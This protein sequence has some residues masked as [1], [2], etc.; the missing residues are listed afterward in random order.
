MWINWKRF[1]SG[2]FLLASLS[3]LLFGCSDL[4]S[5]QTAQNGATKSISGVVSDPDTGLPL[6]NAKVTAYAIDASGAE[7]TTALSV[8]PASVTSNQKGA[9]LLHIPADYS[10][11]LMIEAEVPPTELVGKLS[12]LVFSTAG[13]KIRSAVPKNVISKTTI[14]PVMV[15]FATDAVYVFVQQNSATGGF[16]SDNI[17]KATIILETFFGPNFT[18][19]PPPKSATDSNTSK[20]QQDLIVSIIALNSV[21]GNSNNG[22]NMATIVTA[23]VSDTGLGSII[24]DSIKSGVTAAATT[25]AAAGTLPPEYL[26]SVAINT[27][28]SNAQSAPV[29]TPVLTDTT[30]PSAPANLVATPVSAKNVNLTWDAATDSGANPT[31][32]AGYSICR[33][34]SSNVY[35]TIDTVGPS[36]TSYSDFFAAAQTGYSYKVI[37]FDGARNLSE[38]SNVSS[39]TT[40]QAT[41]SIPPSKPAGLVCKGLIDAQNGLPA[42]IKTQWLQSTKTN[43]DGT[44]IPAA[45]YNVYR[46]SQLIATVAETSYSDKTVLAGTDYTYYVKASDA[47][48]DLSLASQTLTIRIPAAADAT[49]PVTTDLALQSPVLYNKVPLA[50]TASTRGGVTCNVYRDAVLI[51]TGIKGGT[52]SDASVSPRSKYVYTVTASSGSGESS[53]GNQLA[54]TTPANPN[55]TDTAPPT[56]P[57]NLV[58]VSVT[59]RS[60]PLT[61]T[62]STK[63]DGDKI[64]AGYDVLRGDGTGKGF[65]KIATVGQPGYTDTTVVPSTAYSYQ[66]MSFGSAG[67]RSDASAA[68]VVTT[69]TAVNLADTTAPTSPALALDSPATSGAVPLAWTASTKS[70]GDQVV[71]GYLVYRD[72]AQIADVKSGLSFTDTTMVAGTA[73]AY[74]VKA[75]DNAGNLSAASNELHVATPAAAPNTYTIYGK[76][77]LNGAG[78]AGVILSN[79]TIS[80]VS[81]AN[82]NYSFT[83]VANGSYSL[84]PSSTGY[85]RFT[86]TSR[87]VFISNANVP[88]QDFA[89]M[90]SGT[91]TGG[92]TY[93]DGTIIGGITYP[94]GTVIGGVLYPSATVIGGVTYPTGTVIGGVLY[95]NGVIVGGV[96]YPSGTV[97]G[98]TAFPVG[99]LTAG[100]IYPTGTLIGGVIYPTG[101]VVGGVIYPTGAVTGGVGFPAGSVVG[102]LGWLP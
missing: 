53:P 54:V 57:A 23:L 95:P 68:W 32:V 75:Y 37:A 14:P 90:L 70:N 17:Q 56:V 5:S 60:V 97:V 49:L 41:D 7:S 92:V 82:G 64:V 89:A 15:S 65:V 28:I 88:G 51:A 47:N 43:G 4:G 76:V 16:S 100:L 22:T 81:D 93:P 48:S 67:L 74:T 83:G 87:T 77:T 33:A 40:L 71:A 18:Q 69:P 8:Y 102:A 13:R 42:Q 38:S 30:P 1:T 39:V 34:D 24:A 10:G 101:T 86:P 91:V 46:D 73:Y 21:I 2:A 99:Y 9:Y 59:S 35:V 6:T 80:I 85:Y 20:A 62:A 36:A 31:G 55:L 11:S 50:W 84:T 98:G 3:L 26:P 96:A 58:A 19:T 61:W 78:L 94:T 52:Y 29:P 44:V 63:A 66:V 79:G 27:A 12:K 45:G 25:L 72:G